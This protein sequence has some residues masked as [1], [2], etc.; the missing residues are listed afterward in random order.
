MPWNNIE[1]DASLSLKNTLTAKIRRE[2]VDLGTQ[3]LTG[4]SPTLDQTSSMQGETEKTL[5][6]HIIIDDKGS[7]LY[8]IKQPTDTSSS[9]GL[10]HKQDQKEKN[11]RKER[12]KNADT[13]RS[14]K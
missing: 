1:E 3:T 10:Q 11:K 7:P 12:E 2:P 14:M 6:K 4:P 13:D 5:F 8:I 9:L